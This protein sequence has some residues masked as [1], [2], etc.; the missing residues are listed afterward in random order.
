MPTIGEAMAMEFV[1]ECANTRKVIERVPEDK[2]D[3]KPHEKSMTM[4]QLASHIAEGYAWTRV[5]V[6]QDEFALDP[7]EHT[8]F[9]ASSMA[10]PL[11][12]FDASA[13][14]AI[15][16]IR[17]CGDEAMMRTWRMK[18][19]DRVAL[20]MPRVAVLRSMIMNH[21]IHHRGQLEVYLRMNDVPLPQIYGPTADEPDMA[22]AG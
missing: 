16:A 11:E 4:G 7:D 5:T 22:P 3:F 1:H 20:E 14:D 15:E 8:P 10:E 12:K 2:F 19:G 13:A 6:E 18:V 9:V 21:T 17:G